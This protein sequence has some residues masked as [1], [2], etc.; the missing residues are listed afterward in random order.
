MEQ[1]S[2]SP[3]K[4]SSKWP[5]LTNLTYFEEK[6]ARWNFEEFRQI[7]TAVEGGD[8]NNKR[9]DSVIKSTTIA[10]DNKAPST[11]ITKDCGSARQRRQP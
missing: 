1:V 3:T 10:P 2:G 4:H 9:R 8:C 6:N 11:V 7:I 5:Q